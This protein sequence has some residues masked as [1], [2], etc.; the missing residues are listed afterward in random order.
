MQ[1][2]GPGTSLTESSPTSPFELGMLAIKRREEERGCAIGWHNVYKDA[3][4]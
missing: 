2:E 3:L 4:F 1:E